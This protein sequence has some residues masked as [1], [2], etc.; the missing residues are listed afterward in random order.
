MRDRPD[1]V[2]VVRSLASRVASCGAFGVAFSLV[3]LFETKRDV[4]AR[5]F[6]VGPSFDSPF[7]LFNVI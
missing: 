4:G 6:E 3:G 7:L 5:L 2:L 1:L